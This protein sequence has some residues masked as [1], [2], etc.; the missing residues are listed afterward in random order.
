MACEYCMIILHETTFCMWQFSSN[1]TPLKLYTYGFLKFPNVQFS[2]CLIS[3]GYSILPYSTKR[4]QNEVHFTSNI[5]EQR[6]R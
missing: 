4:V 3:C 1:N 5:R 6:K 2:L